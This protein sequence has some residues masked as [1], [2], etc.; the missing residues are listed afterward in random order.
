MV[1]RFGVRSRQSRL[2]GCGAGSVFFGCRGG[3]ASGSESVQ[4]SP[5]TSHLIPV[6]GGILLLCAQH[7]FHLLCL[8]LRGCPCGP[9]GPGPAPRTQSILPRRPNHPRRWHRPRRAVLG[10][11]DHPR[12]RGRALRLRLRQGH[13]KKAKR[14]SL[15]ILRE[16]R[17]GSRRGGGWGGRCLPACLSCSFHPLST[18]SLL[19]SLSSPPSDSPCVPDWRWSVLPCLFLQRV[20]LDKVNKCVLFIRSRDTVAISSLPHEHNVACT[21]ACT[22]AVLA[23][24]YSLGA[25]HY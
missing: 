4:P 9:A 21:P 24:A 14:R 2:P 7:G 13:R 3:S 15:R 11:Y 12:H 5:C 18:L 10:R 16:S 6:T 17:E 25:P 19:S 22:R 1:R 8:R 20:F 23:I